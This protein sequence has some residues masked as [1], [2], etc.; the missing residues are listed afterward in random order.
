M[1]LR[2]AATTAIGGSSPR[3]PSMRGAR[4]ACTVCAHRRMH[5]NLHSKAHARRS[6]SGPRGAGGAAGRRPD[7]PGGGRGGRAGPRGLAGRG[8]GMEATSAGSDRRAGAAPALVALALAYG[9]AHNGYRKR[10]RQMPAMR[11]E[12]SFEFLGD[13][14]GDQEDD[15][16]VDLAQGLPSLFPRPRSCPAPY[17]TDGCWSCRSRQGQVPVVRGNEERR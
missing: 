4:T 11:T 13:G 1:I 10:G 5:Q 7:A 6:T 2:R 9:Y 14:V 8:G 15:H 3:P 16:A 17:I 12:R